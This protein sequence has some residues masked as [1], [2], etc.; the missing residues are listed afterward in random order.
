V[1][2]PGVFETFPAGTH[3]TIESFIRTLSGEA[4]IGIFLSDPE[5]HTLYVNDRLR[6][7]AGLPSAATSRDCWLQALSPEDHD[8]I[9]A[10]WASAIADHRSF[11]REFRFQRPDGS[12]RWVMA[13]AFPLRTHG[14]IS[15]G[16]VG[17]VRDVTPRQLAMEALHTSEERYRNLMLASPQA[18][19]V[20]ADE[21]I[22]FINQ[23]GTRLFGLT[24]AQ[25][26]EGRQLTECF[27]EEFVRGLLPG[28]NL[29]ISTPPA[30]AEQRLEREDGNSIDVEMVATPTAFH[31]HPAVQVVITDIT[32]QKD[33]AARLQEAKKTAAIATLAG[34]IA[35]EFNNCLTAIM[36]FSDLALPL[37]M[38]DSRPHGHIQQVL[39][40]SKRARDLVTQMLVFGRQAGNTKQPIS[41]DILLKETLRILRGRLSKN[42]TLREWIAGAITPILADP[43]QIHQVCLSLLAHS[44]QAMKSTGGILEVRLDNIQL[45]VAGNGHDLPLPA[46]LYVRMTVSDTVEGVSPDI[47]AR[48]CDPFVTPA[49]EGVGAGAEF[50]DVQ[51]IVSEHGGTFRATSTVAQGTIIEVYLPAMPYPSSVV[52]TEPVPGAASTLTEGK[53]FLAERDKER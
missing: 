28:E 7:M 48:L 17:M 9:S 8:V 13:E 40:A 15:T 14:G 31:G 33:L 20:H 39:L 23:A 10:E 6:R 47:Q 52:I 2:S 41:L 34:G 45:A 29:G 42:I 53:E 16:Y 19:L 18:I 49:A 27:P 50:A 12:I 44:E 51:T 5:G 37:L 26:I 30:R 1:T 11:S 24:S 21:A 38:P 25:D 43:T 4:S 35:H 3:S 32:A 22:L 46:G 36:G